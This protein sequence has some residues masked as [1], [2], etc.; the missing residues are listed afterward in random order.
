MITEEQTRLILDAV[1]AA[2][3]AQLAFTQETRQA[4]VPAHL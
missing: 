4:P 2:F 3:D 1:D